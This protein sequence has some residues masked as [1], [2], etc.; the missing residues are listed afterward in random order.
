SQTYGPISA[1]ETVNF[2]CVK[3]AENEISGVIK[4]EFGNS[5]SLS[6]DS[7]IIVKAYRSGNTGGFETKVQ[8][9]MVGTFTIEGLDAGKTYQLKFIFIQNN[10]VLKS[11]WAGDNGVGVDERVDANGFETNKEILFQFKN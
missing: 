6:A 2:V 8:A 9:E 10:G 4:D 5:V 1:N 7:K 11:Q 3:S